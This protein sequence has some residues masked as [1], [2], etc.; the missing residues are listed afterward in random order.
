MA[1]NFPTCIGELTNEWLSTALGGQVTGYETT[2]LEG[3]VLSDAFKLHAITYAGDVGGAPKSV[4]VKVANGVKDRRDF[5]LLG[6]AYTKEL[7]FFQEL[8]SEV[9]LRSPKL[10]ACESDGSEGSEFFIIVMEDLSEIGRAHV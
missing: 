6:N 9:P 1:T 5:A 8:A 3:G 4:V 10:Y 2:F 7:R